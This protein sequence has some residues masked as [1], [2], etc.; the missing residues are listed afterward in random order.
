MGAPT[1]DAAWLTRFVGQVLDEDLEPTGDVTS[2]A[3][4][5]EERIVTAHLVA[6]GPFVLAGIDVARLLY[7]CLDP[8]VCF[9]ALEADGSELAPGGRAARLHG[10]A[11]SILAGERAALNLLMRMSGI[12]TATRAAVQEIEGTGAVILDTRKTAPGL[13][14][15]DKYSVAVGGGTNHRAGL[16]ATRCA[17]THSG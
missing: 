15:L 5:P 3:V 17:V 9:E 12:A 7:H 6:R 1:L 8:R 2:V 16:H 14:R 10:P 13:R 4:L 11:R